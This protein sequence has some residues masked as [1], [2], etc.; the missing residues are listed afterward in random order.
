M[1]EFAELDT[2]VECRLNDTE[3][4]SKDFF[5]KE[6]F[7]KILLSVRNRTSTIAIYLGE[8]KATTDLEKPNTFNEI[9]QSVV[10]ASLE[11]ESKPIK[12]ASILIDKVNFL[13]LDVMLILEILDVNKALDAL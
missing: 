9:F 2:F 13:E 1:E 11:Y 5:Q 12:S 10:V 4:I 7:L 6:N 8:K 3:R